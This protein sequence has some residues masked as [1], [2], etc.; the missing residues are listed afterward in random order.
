MGL[1]GWRFALAFPTQDRADALAAGTTP[2][3]SMAY[4]RA[5]TAYESAIGSGMRHAVAIDT[6]TF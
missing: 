4:R 5:T 6:H 1:S 3:Q 2:S